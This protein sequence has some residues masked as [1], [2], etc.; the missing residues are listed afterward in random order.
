MKLY[1]NVQTIKD[2]FGSSNNATQDVEF[3]ADK[4]AKELWVLSAEKISKIRASNGKLYYYYRPLDV[5]D[6]ERAKLLMKRNG[7]H[8]K[9]HKSNFFMVKRTVLRVLVKDVDTKKECIEFIKKV[10]ANILTTED[11]VKQQNIKSR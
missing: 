5:N 11:V 4:D 9:V 10:N 2:F 6:I 3:N 7:L 1:K 8:P